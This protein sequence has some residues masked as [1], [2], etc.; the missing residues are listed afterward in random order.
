MNSFGISLQTSQECL[1]KGDSMS[2]FRLGWKFIFQIKVPWWIL[3]VT[4]TSIF[5]NILSM[6][7]RKLRHGF[8]NK[9]LNRSQI[10]TDI[11][12]LSESVMWNVYLSAC[13]N[14]SKLIDQFL[15]NATEEFSLRPGWDWTDII[16]YLLLSWSWIIMNFWELNRRVIRNWRG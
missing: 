15:L 3:V 13:W 7:I 14:M 9:M 2:R 11:D 16:F 12:S 1:L 4:N 5:K 10:P 6:D 8:W